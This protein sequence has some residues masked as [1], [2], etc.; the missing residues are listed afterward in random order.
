MTSIFQEEGDMS[1]ENECSQEFLLNI[2]CNG[3]MG[4]PISF[5]DKY[6]PEQFSIIGHTHSGDKS[7]AVNLLRTNPKMR[8]R[9][10][11]RGRQVYDR[12][13]IKHKEQP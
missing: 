10:Y 8:H 11:I 12:I 9:G 2:R 13:L 5:L 6:C 1:M 7:K 3:V 4:V